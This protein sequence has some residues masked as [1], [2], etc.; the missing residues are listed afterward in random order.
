MSSSESPTFPATS[1]MCRSFASC[2][3][4]MSVFTV[5]SPV[6]IFMALIS[7]RFSPA[8]SSVFCE[9]GG[10][11]L[12]PPLRGSQEGGGASKESFETLNLL[13][14]GGIH[15]R[16]GR[17][18]LA[19]TFAFLSDETNERTSKLNHMRTFPRTILFKATPL[20]S[21]RRCGKTPT[22]QG[23]GKRGASLGGGALPSAN[24]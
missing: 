13:A 23:V 10:G 16:R 24:D 17:H 14:L 12:A 6:K 8:V 18:N 15:F 22:P 5:L 2:A 4:S 21:C 1:R 20:P 11:F 3:I 7:F 19:I 9:A